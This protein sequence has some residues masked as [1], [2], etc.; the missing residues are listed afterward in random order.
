MMRYWAATQLGWRETQRLEHT[1]ADG[2]PLEFTKIER[3]VIRGKA[4]A[5]NSNA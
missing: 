5:E 4:D 1:G 3:V 2:A